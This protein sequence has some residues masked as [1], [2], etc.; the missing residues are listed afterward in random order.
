MKVLNGVQMTPDLQS[1][2]TLCNDRDIW[3]CQSFCMQKTYNQTR[4]LWQNL[5]FFFEN[6][7]AKNYRLNSK[8]WS[9]CLHC[10]AGSDHDLHW[11]HRRT[12]YLLVSSRVITDV[13]HDHS[14][15][16]PASV[17]FHA[18]SARRLKWSRTKLRT[19]IYATV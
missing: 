7:R 10:C 19:K 11:P 5:D 8:Q 3:N 1:Y 16:W 2:W 4:E 17:V 18:Y 14:I 6:S 13:I 9:S 12:Q 15:T